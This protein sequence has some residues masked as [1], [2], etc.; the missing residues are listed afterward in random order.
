MKWL[1]LALFAVLTAIPMTASAQVYVPIGK[2]AT[3]DDRSATTWGMSGME[4]L[5]IKTSDGNITPIM[6]T[7][8][9]DARTVEILSRVQ[10]PPVRP[11]DV[12]V[13]NKNGRA[14]IVVRNYYLL[15]V[16][17]QDARSEGTSTMALANKWAS[18]IRK[19]LPQ[20][21]PMPNRIGI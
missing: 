2:I 4:I 10:A 9:F 6:R 16:K 5:R 8:T 14:L 13:L 11:S 19:V 3:V 12:R 17:P 18:S 21:A 20:V 15:E 7:E 1:A